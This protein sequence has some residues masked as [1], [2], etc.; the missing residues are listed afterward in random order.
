MSDETKELEEFKKTLQEAKFRLFY[1]FPFWAM[2]VESCPIYTSKQ[3]PTACINE[4]SQIFINV[5]FWEKLTVGQ[6]AFLLAHEVA[7]RA[8][9]HLRRR[10]TRDPYIFNCAADFAINYMLMGDMQQPSG[11]PVMPEGG[12]YDPKYGDMTAEE[13]YELLLK[14]GTNS[15]SGG[16]SS[17]SGGS[18]SGTAGQNSG[19]LSDKGSGAA[20]T[21]DLGKTPS[22]GV[23]VADAGDGTPMSNEEWEQKVADA[24]RVSEEVIK[25]RGDMPAG[26]RRE[27]N[28]LLSPK[29]DWLTQLRTLIRQSVAGPFNGDMQWLPPSRRFVHTGWFFPRINE[30]MGPKIVCAVD[31]SGSM[32]EYELEQAITEIEEARRQFNARVYMMSCD[33]ATYGAGWVEPT[34]SLPTLR[35]GGGTSFVPVFNKI[36]EEDLDPDVLLFFT[37]TYGL[38]PP[39]APEY[40][41][42]WITHSRNVRI[43]FG[44]LVEIEDR[45]Y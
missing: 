27:I 1:E 21:D 20:L 36:E 3:I 8:F 30:G 22:D 44:T 5:E 4:T 38:F 40:P 12:L 2:L 43:P 6:R 10:G 13:I 7:H 35:G 39:K 28:R 33:A 42:I 17:P 31:T 15:G 24:A 9:D 19:N 25:T 37:D 29:V 32:S 34:E 23:K 26:L 41:T 11:P 18:T 16:M 14:Q 45:T